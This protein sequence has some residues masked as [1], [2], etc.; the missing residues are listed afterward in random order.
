MPSSRPA[1]RFLD[2]LDNIRLIQSYLQ[3]MDRAAFEADSFSVNDCG[4]SSFR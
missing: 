2:I 3:G 4:D 1:T